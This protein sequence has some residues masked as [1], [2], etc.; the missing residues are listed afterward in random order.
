MKHLLFLFAILALVYACSKKVYSNTDE[1]HGL[2][3]MTSFVAFMPARPEFEEEDIQWHFNA[4]KNTVVVKHKYPA[5]TDFGLRPGN[6][7]YTRS[8][9]TLRID[10]SD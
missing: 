9:K 6:Y 7:R 1:L 5:K 8:G 2:W 3:T 10:G 4:T